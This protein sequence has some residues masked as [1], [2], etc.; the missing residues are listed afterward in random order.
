MFEKLFEACVIRLKED[1]KIINFLTL[2][3]FYS[4]EW[5]IAKAIASNRR[6]KFFSKMLA[7]Y[8]NLC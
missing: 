3:W 8:G 6:K 5:K 4:D 7:Y 1:L 2:T